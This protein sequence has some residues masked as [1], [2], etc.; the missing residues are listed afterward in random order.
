MSKE[1]AKNNG[2]SARLWASLLKVLRLGLRNGKAEVTRD[3]PF[4]DV[5]DQPG[6]G[7]GTDH[8]G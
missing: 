6:S 5:P 2:F 3:R 4:S 8:F 7:F 1:K